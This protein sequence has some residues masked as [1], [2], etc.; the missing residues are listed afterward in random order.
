MVLESNNHSV[1]SLHYHLVFVVKYRRKA[2]D[3]TISEKL[4]EIFEYIQPSYNITLQEWNHDQDHVHIL[5]SAHP[6]T[7]LT[8][9][10]NAYKSAKQSAH[11][12]GVPRDTSAFMERAILEPEFLPY[13]RRRR[14]H[15]SIAS[16]H[17]KPG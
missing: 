2:I 12:E 1:F 3:D 6:K 8:K 10:I 4:K 11:K 13:Q 15:R 9:F 16:V 5:F 7:E 14:S 17:R